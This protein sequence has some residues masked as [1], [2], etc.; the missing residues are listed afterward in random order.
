MESGS[1]GRKQRSAAGNVKLRILEHR[2]GCGTRQGRGTE[3]G[4]E[5]GLSARFD[6]QEIKRA[7]REKKPAKSWK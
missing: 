1:G 5:S 4:L 2:K 7:A 6:P 3:G